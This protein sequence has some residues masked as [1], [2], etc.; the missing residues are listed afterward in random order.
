MRGL[1]ERVDVV[2][3]AYS[4][5]MP[6]ISGQLSRVGVRTVRVEVAARD[7]AALRRRRLWCLSRWVT[8][9]RPVVLQLGS[10]A[11]SGGG[12]CVTFTV[13]HDLCIQ[14]PSAEERLPVAV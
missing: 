7:V 2:L 3:S 1:E 12:F 11:S 8:D 9:P 10:M 5:D 14:T 13:R 4:M 6:P